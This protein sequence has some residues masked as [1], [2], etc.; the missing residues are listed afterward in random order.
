[1]QVFVDGCPWKKMVKW[2]SHRISLLC[3]LR[4][5]QIVVEG[6]GSGLIE[7]VR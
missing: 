4:L 2:C 3:E 7:K 6:G 5:T 1:M